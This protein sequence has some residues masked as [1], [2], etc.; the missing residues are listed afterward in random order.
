MVTGD[1]AEVA[2][3]VGA[4][5]GVD[6]VLAELH[7]G[8]TSSTRSAPSSAGRRP[9]WSAT[10]STTRPRWP[11][12][13][14]GSRWEPAAPPPRPRPPTWCSPS[15][16]ST[17]SARWPRSPA[18]PSRIALQSVLA[19]MGLSLAAM[20]VAAA[21]LLPAVW[22]ALLQEAHRRRGDPQRAARAAPAPLP[23]VRLAAADAALDQAVP[24]R[25]RGDPGRASS[26][27]GPPPTRSDRPRPGDARRSAQ[28]NELLDRAR[29]GRTSRPRSTSCTRPWTGCS[30]ATT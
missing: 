12:P 24:G 20:G 27:C 2:D 14:S 30:A 25:A 28:V 13:T 16:S 29:S 19:G 17:A 18:A 3:A 1:R 21:G 4:V 26:S 10:A 11:S 15:T 5:I 7:P 9:S 8:R 23:S 6:E 22:G